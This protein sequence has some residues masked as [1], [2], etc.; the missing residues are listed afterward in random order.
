VTV[1]AD[2]VIHGP[3]NIENYVTANKFR[4]SQIPSPSIEPE[5]RY[6]FVQLSSL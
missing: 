2:Y 3:V 5:K 6:F 4:S 1:V